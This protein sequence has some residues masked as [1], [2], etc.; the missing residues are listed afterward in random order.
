MGNAT[1]PDWKAQKKRPRSSGLEG[2]DP[3]SECLISCIAPPELC[4]IGT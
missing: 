2:S 1:L 3:T 4:V